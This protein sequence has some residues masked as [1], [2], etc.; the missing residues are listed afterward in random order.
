MKRYENDSIEQ[1][2]FKTLLESP[3]TTGEI[4]RALGY[5]KTEYHNVTPALNRLKSAGYIHGE[6]LK[7]KSRKGQPPT[8]YNII[9]EISTL[10]KILDKYQLITSYLQ[11]ND[12]ILSLVVE[13]HFW[14]IDY[15]KK[16]AEHN[17]RLEDET[18]L[19]MCDKC[20]ENLHEPTQC[21]FDDKQRQECLE[22]SKNPEPPILINQDV[23]TLAKEGG[24]FLKRFAESVQ[25]ELK[26]EFKN[27]LRISPYFFRVCLTNT[28]EELKEQLDLLYGLTLDAHIEKH[29]FDIL[30]I[31]NE[32]EAI[33]KAYFDK[34]FEISVFYDIMNK[35]ASEDAKKEISEMNKHKA[36]VL[37]DIERLELKAYFEDPQIS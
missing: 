1:K 32:P 2:I 36:H 37:E 18:G 22:L 6:I 17:K 28:P 35:E 5:K 16:N 21:G 9:L 34:I 7:E 25:N 15:K 14:L 4:V 30:T 33:L 8:I 27:R 29:P 23:E 24:E 31:G 11:K 3:K 10:N 19:N 20:L 12:K 26:I 13:T